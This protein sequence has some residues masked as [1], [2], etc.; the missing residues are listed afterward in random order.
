M[1]GKLEYLGDCWGIC[2]ARLERGVG[3]SS[4]LPSAAVNY[5][6]D[7]SDGATVQ[8]ARLDKERE[9][10]LFRAQLGAT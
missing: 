8:P 6:R 1:T 3:Q 10:S 9:P 2:I 4:R 7:V 5:T